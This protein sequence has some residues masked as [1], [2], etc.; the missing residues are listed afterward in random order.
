[1]KKKTILEETWIYRP[2]NNKESEKEKERRKG[3]EKGMA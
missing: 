2:N 1:M 3:I